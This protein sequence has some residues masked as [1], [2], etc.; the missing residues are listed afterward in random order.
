MSSNRNRKK[1][2]GGFEITQERIE[3]INKATEYMNKMGDFA[4]WCENNFYGTNVEQCYNIFKDFVKSNEHLMPKI[5][6]LM[7]PP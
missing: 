6:K 2:E 7:P 3:V 5:N 1:A 4:E